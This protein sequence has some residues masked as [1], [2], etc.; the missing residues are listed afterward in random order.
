MHFPLKKWTEIK[1]EDGNLG[2][3]QNNLRRESKSTNQKSTAVG[4]QSTEKCI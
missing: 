1:S 2:Q 4:Y 3:V